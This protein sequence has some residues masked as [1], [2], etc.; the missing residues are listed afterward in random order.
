[1]SEPNYN[2]GSFYTGKESEDEPQAT[3]IEI[4]EFKKQYDAMTRDEKARLPTWLR[5]HLERM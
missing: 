2:R 5:E 1:M 4:Q 3:A